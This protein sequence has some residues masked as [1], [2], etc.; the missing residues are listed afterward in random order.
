M[1]RNETQNTARTEMRLS[2][3]SY[4]EMRLSKMITPENT[5]SNKLLCVNVIGVFLMVINGW[6]Q[7]NITQIDANENQ[8][9]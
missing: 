2:N 6:M 5:N 7:I 3:I 8:S 1:H 9:T 4:T